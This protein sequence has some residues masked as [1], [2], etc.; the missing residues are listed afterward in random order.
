LGPT[1]VWVS[2]EHPPRRK[3]QLSIEASFARF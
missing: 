3:E 1:A 2:P